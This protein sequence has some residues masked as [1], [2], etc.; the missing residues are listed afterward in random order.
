MNKD[1]TDNNNKD[2]KIKF[3]RLINE[4]SR[5]YISYFENFTS[6]YSLQCIDF[7][8]FTLSIYAFAFIFSIIDD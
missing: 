3:L 5:M 4:G 1:R 2:F 8:F 6:W 7:K